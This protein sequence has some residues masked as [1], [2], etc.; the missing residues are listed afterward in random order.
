MAISNTAEGNLIK[1]TFEDQFLAR[2]GEYVNHYAMRDEEAH[3]DVGY[4]TEASEPTASRI[5]VRLSTITEKM[6]KTY[7][8]LGMSEVDDHVLYSKID[9]NVKERDEIERDNGERYEVLGQL[10][11]GK[12]GAVHIF[13]THALRR[14]RN[15]SE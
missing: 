3:A 8:D 5:L 15:V 11:H 12:V 4:L 14:R 6:Q 9:S 1:S 10:H 2:A 7:P 13:N